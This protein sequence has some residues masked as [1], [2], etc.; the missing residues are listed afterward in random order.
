MYVIHTSR[1]IAIVA[2]MKLIHYDYEKPT[3]IFIAAAAVG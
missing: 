3:N 2:V 1:Q